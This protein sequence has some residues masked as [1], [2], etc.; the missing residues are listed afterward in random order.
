MCFWNCIIEMFWGLALLLL[1]TAS[2]LVCS[3]FGRRC[4][5]GRHR[6]ISLNARDKPLVPKV[7]HPT[8]E[9]KESHS[10]D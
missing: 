2:L 7:G 4:V 5:G 1:S 6:S 8:F 9:R 10:G 3:A